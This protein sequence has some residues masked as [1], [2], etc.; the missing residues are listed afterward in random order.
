MSGNAVK[1]ATGTLEAYGF[2]TANYADDTDGLAVLVRSHP[3]CRDTGYPSAT[4][5]LAATSLVLRTPQ[6]KKVINLSGCA[7][8]RDFVGDSLAKSR[9]S[10]AGLTLGSAGYAN[11]Q[12]TR[13]AIQKP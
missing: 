13:K 1:V 12:T 3:G 2:S 8:K 5:G 11:T 7:E 9:L 4:D 10:V 6:D